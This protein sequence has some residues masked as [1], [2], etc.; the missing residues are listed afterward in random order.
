MGHAILSPSA[1]E[2][3]SNCT[4]SARMELAFPDKGST[5]AEEGTLAHAVAE[6]ILNL[7]L[8]R[9]KKKEF[10][11]FIAICE[12]DPLYSAELYQYAEN[13]SEFVLERYAEAVSRTPDAQIYTERR[14]DLTAIIPDGFG[15]ADVI[16]LADGFMEVIDLKYG[17][18]VEVSA[19]DN[20]QLKIYGLG[21]LEEFA[22]MYN[23]ESL[24]LTIYQ[25]RIGNFSS[26]EI[27]SIDL[28][29]WAYE[30]LKFKA[31]AA[32]NGEGELVPGKHCKFCKAKAVCRAFHDQNIEIAKHEFKEP[33]LLNPAEIANVLNMADQVKEWI[34]AVETY[35]LSKALE[36]EKWPGYKLVEGRS[37][38]VITDAD[39][40]A[41]QLILNGYKTDQI[42][43]LKMKGITALE[44]ELTKAKFNELLGDYILKPPGKPTLVP[45][46]DKRAE[47]NSADAAEND[48]KN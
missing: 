23:I 18:G 6:S 3:W 37:V 20:K 32:F 19:A 21:A 8:G 14:L 22:I 33:D 47:I 44:K 39:Q 48:F 40:A 10:Y 17:K 2:R 45:A 26:F 35:A 46:S 41:K 12:Q 13:F 38:R 5:A 15:T 27:S 7:K 42:Y 31:A 4:P 25:P 34:T 11:S 28:I 30:D 1:A 29:Q 16:I 9:I 24:K 36:G 43:D